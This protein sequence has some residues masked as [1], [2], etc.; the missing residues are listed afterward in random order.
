MEEY[1]EIRHGRLSFPALNGGLVAHRVKQYFVFLGGWLN[2][3][4]QVVGFLWKI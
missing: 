3:A 2:R 4:S 1:N